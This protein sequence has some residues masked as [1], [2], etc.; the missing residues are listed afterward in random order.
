MILFIFCALSHYSVS[1]VPIKV[2]MEKAGYILK[3]SWSVLLE[4]TWFL[5]SDLTVPHELSL[6]NASSDLLRTVIKKRQSLQIFP[7][8]LPLINAYSISDCPGKPLPPFSF[9]PQLLPDQPPSRPSPG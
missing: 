9:P 1:S 3:R 7:Q 5:F 8:R 2:Q 6:K 4:I